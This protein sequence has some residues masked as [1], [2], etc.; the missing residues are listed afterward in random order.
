MFGFVFLELKWNIRMLKMC[1]CICWVIT[2]V[3]MLVIEQTLEV[4]S[5]LLLVSQEILRWT[6]IQE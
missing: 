1:L 3:D 2:E 4:A 5:D 6:D